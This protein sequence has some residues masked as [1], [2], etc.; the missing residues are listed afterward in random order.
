ML[1]SQPYIQEDG[2]V[3]VLIRLAQYISNETRFFFSMLQRICNKFS[4]V[5]F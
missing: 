5:S 3:I 2:K 1:G 4:G